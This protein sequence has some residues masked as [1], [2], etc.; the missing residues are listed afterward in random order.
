MEKI[1]AY[2]KNRT[3]D[4]HVR[5]QSLDPYASTTAKIESLIN[6]NENQRSSTM[7]R[8]QKLVQKLVHFIEE[9]FIFPF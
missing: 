5:G 4:L 9:G 8:N 7:R 2:S 1:S 6:V 3:W